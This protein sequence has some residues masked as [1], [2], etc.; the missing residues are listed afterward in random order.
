MCD[1]YRARHIRIGKAVA[2]KIDRHTRTITAET[3][4]I[5]RPDGAPFSFATGQVRVAAA[6]G[7]AAI[8]CKA[9]KI[10]STDEKKIYNL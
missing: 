2:I 1:V 3:N 4:R 7:F 6:R 5:N 8:R 9:G 10:M